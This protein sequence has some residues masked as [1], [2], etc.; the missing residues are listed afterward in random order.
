MF[1]APTTPPTMAVLR[2]RPL[3][4]LPLILLALAGCAASDDPLALEKAGQPEPY[5]PKTELTLVANCV[6]NTPQMTLDGATSG[7][8]PF[9]A[10][11]ARLTIINQCSVYPLRYE[12]SDNYNA[13]PGELSDKGLVA[14]QKTIS[15]LFYSSRTKN[16]VPLFS[17]RY[18]GGKVK[19]T[20]ITFTPEARN[21]ESPV[22]L[23]NTTNPYTTYLT[24]EHHSYP[25]NDK[26]KTEL[27]TF[28]ARL[29]NHRSTS[30]EIPLADLQRCVDIARSPSSRPSEAG[31][32]RTSEA[33]VVWDSVGKIVSVAQL[34]KERR[35]NH[36]AACKASGSSVINTVCSI[37]GDNPGMYL[38]RWLLQNQQPNEPPLTAVASPV[39]YD[40]FFSK[41][42]AS[43]RVRNTTSASDAWLVTFKQGSA[44][45]CADV[46][47]AK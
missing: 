47:K 26:V 3:A 41:C 17:F 5:P 11:P 18:D 43:E 42:K 12:F 28:G 32:K 9:T 40:R 2:R 13:V 45:Q 44:T 7:Y 10:S 14:K 38:L 25:L 1:D 19:S 33:Y 22:P 6:N 34:T 36:D 27:D 29:Y 8:Y 30:T 23:T 37:G 31:L 46:P 21:A 20:R 24:P 35:Q 16:E 39:L 15:G 4:P